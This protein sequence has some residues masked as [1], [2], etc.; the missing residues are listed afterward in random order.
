MGNFGGSNSRREGGARRGSSSDRGG[1]SRSGGFG[2]N[3][4]GDRFGSGDRY[5]GGSGSF[6]SDRPRS[7]FGPREM[8][9]AI[10]AECNAECDVPFKPIANKPVYCRDCFNK[11]K[12][13]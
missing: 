13:F 1:S 12:T 8:H 6:N 7:N 10:C 4:G 11:R 5:G 2:G 9:K 3:G